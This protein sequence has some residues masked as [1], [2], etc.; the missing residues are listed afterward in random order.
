MK[1]QIESMFLMNLGDRE[2][3]PPLLRTKRPIVNRQT[4]R[5]E[6]AELT[7]LIFKEAIERYNSGAY[8][9]MEEVLVKVLNDFYYQHNMAEVPPLSASSNAWCGVGNRPSQALAASFE[10]CVGG[11][12]T[13][14]VAGAPRTSLALHVPHRLG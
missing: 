14:R 10:L 9:H 2:D 8:P 6:A 12:R 13:S 5:E 3:V 1:E 11:R 4:S 7:T